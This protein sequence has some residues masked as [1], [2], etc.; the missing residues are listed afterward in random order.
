MGDTAAARI[1]EARRRAAALPSVDDPLVLDLLRMGFTWDGP[2]PAVLDLWR[3][4][5]REAVAVAL[6]ELTRRR[7]A[8]AD[9]EGRG[10]LLSP[11]A[12]LGAIRERWGSQAHFAP[13]GN[14]APVIALAVAPAI[15]LAGAPAARSLSRAGAPE[16]PFRESESDTT[17][18]GP[19]NAAGGGGVDE[20][21]KDPRPECL[22]LLRAA[23]GVR[24]VP[25]LHE[26]ARYPLPVVQAG[27]R[28]AKGSQADTKAPDWGRFCRLHI[29]SG[30]AAAEAVKAA[31]RDAARANATPVAS[32]Q[33]REQADRDTAERIRAGLALGATLPAP[34][35]LAAIEAEAVAVRSFGAMLERRYPRGDMPADVWAR[36]VATEPR[37]IA[38]IAARLIEA[39]QARGEAV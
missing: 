8:E 14:V 17:T 9:R 4:E 22:T 27:I 10:I 25:V 32:D 23:G 39:G 6:G 35:I 24:I 7:Q 3:Q 29:E 12:L 19:G 33:A 5:G 28:L 30:A 18:T 2:G 1:A 26:L 36:R 16:F 11:G 21:A 13:A 37:V 34:V 38:F 20:R 15:A 31:A